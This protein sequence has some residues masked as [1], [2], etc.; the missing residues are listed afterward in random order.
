MENLLKCFAV[1]DN[2]YVAATTPAEALA[3]M[4]EMCGDESFDDD[5]E[6]H[7]VVGALLDHRWRDEEGGG[8]AGSLR[9]WMAATTKPEWIAGTEG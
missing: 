2:D 6:V 4:R 7:E 5:E 3:I 8:D 1:G 9:E